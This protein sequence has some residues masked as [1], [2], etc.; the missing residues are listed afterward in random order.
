MKQST[1][2]LS[3]LLA[4]IMAFSC[5]AVIGNAALAEN[6]VAYDNIDDADLT[7]EQV[8]DLALDLVDNDLL[9]DME[10]ID[11]SIV[12]ELRLNSVDNI[13]TDIEDLTGG[14]VWTIGK[15]LLGDI[16]DMNFDALGGVRR[17]GGDLNVINALLQFLADNAG[18]V[19]KIAYGI[20]T[21]N[22]ISLG[23]VGSFL[24]LDKETETMLA[25]LPTFLTS[26][27]FDMLLYGSYNY[28]NDTEELGGI[29]NLPENANTLDEI[30]KEALLQ[31]L[32]DPQDYSWEGEGEDAVKVW[33]DTSKIAALDDFGVS[34]RDELWALINPLNL[35][36]FQILDNIAQPAI[37][38]FGVVALNN[39]LKKALMEAVEVEFNEID[40]AQIKD[41]AVLEYFDNEEAY[42]S[43]IA[44]DAL[45]KASNGVWYYTTLKNK[46]VDADADGVTD[47]DEEGN[48]LYEKQR[49]YYRANFA[50]ANEFATMINWDWNFVASDSS[51]EGTSLLYSELKKDGSIVSG[52]NWLLEKVYDTAL[53]A[54]T[55]ADYE[56]ATGGFVP[57]GND[58]LMEN[59]L[60]LTKY[61]LGNFGEKI[62]GTNSP[63]A[64]Y[65]YDSFA[66]M[67]LVDIIAMIGPGFFEDAMP[68]IILPKNADGSYAFHD[69]VQIWEFAAV[70]LRELITGIAPNV[71]YDAVIFA[72]GDVT[73]ADDRLFEVYDADTWLNILLNM[74]M[75]LAYTYLNNITNFSWNDS[76]R[77]ATT[78]AMASVDDCTEG[79]W[80]SMLD[81]VIMWCVDYVGS[82]SNGVL[83]GISPDAVAAIDG[84][85]NKLDYILNSILPLGLVGEAYTTDGSEE[86]GKAGINLD[87]VLEGAKV[88]LTEFDLTQ[89]L[90]LFGRNYSGYNLLGTT[91][92]VNAVLD[93]VNDIL[94][95]V[96]DTTILQGVNA[97]GTGELT[98][99]ANQSIDAVLTQANLKTTV[100]T[101]LNALNNIKGRLLPTALPVVGKLIDGW[102]TEQEF[103]TP[104]IG[105]SKYYDGENGAIGTAVTVNVRNKSEGVWRHYIDPSTGDAAK[106][107]QYTIIPVSVAAYNY[108]GSTSSYMTPAGLTTSAIGYGGTGSFTFTASAIPTTGAL[109]R[110][111]V[112]YKVTDERGNELLGGK[113]FT[114]TQWTYL[115]YNRTDERTYVENKSTLL[116]AAL[117]T[118]FYVPLSGGVDA[119]RGAQVGKLRRDYKVF[120][121][122]QTGKLTNNSGTVDGL[123]PAS[124]S[125][126]FSNPSRDQDYKSFD[127]LRLFD[128]YTAYADTKEGIHEASVTTISG[129]IN[130]A[131]WLAANKQSGE[132]SVW[133]YTLTDKDGS[134]NRDLVL[135]Y[136]DDVYKD[137]L[138]TLV[139]REL[140]KNPLSAY[141][142][143]T[144][145]S[146]AKEV[147]TSED[148]TDDNGETVLRQ[149]NFATTATVD[150]VEVTAIDNAAAWAEYYAALQYG[151]QVGLQAFNGNKTDWNFKAIYERLQVAANDAEYI[152]KTSTELAASGVEV[153]DAK[154]AIAELQA[155]LDASEATRTDL[156]NFTD[157]KM[158]RLNRYNDAREDVQWYL[159]LLDDASPANVDEIDEY[160]DY[161]WM[162]ENDFRELVAKADN[163]FDATTKANLLALLKKLEAEEK[164]A[165]AAWLQ[166]KKDHLASIQLIDVAMDSNLL[167]LTEDRLLKREGA[168]TY[169]DHINDEIAS[170]ENMITDSSLY[171]ASSWANYADALA[172]AKEAAQT[173]SQKQMFDAKYELLVQ[174]KRLVKI[175]EEADYSELEA[176]IEQAKFALENQDKYQNDNYDFGRV[177]AELGFDEN[178]TVLDR[179]GYEFNL[180]PGSAYEVLYRGYGID[181]QNKVDN[182]ARALKEAL[183]RLKFNEVAVAG[184]GATVNDVTLVE[185]DEEKGIEAVVAKIANISANLD[186]A[187]VKELF[188]VTATGATVGLDN[189]TVS[190]DVNYAVDYETREDFIGF[191]GTNAT[192]TFYTVQGGVKIP[193]ATVKLVVDGDIN[194]DGTVDVLDASYGALIAQEKGEL[195]GCYLLAGN[196]TTTDDTADVKVNTHD[197]SA[198]VN[199][200]LA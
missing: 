99:T 108:D 40:R 37:D 145:T 96:F 38:K 41:V 179:N 88:L 163:N 34:T 109:V 119:I 79:R 11:L 158:Y 160:F 146:Y 21:D 186:E 153:D 64:E 50:A 111:D 100:E 6:D 30:V 94:A 28:P 169:K 155:Q 183:A 89:L 98:T 53:T 7:P 65:T 67:D 12:G 195:T 9:A 147:L 194:G 48:E 31:L 140:D 123:T 75:D 141:Y 121:S 25:N 110:V 68:Q 165:K 76:S 18:R 17:S 62:W 184:T 47:T 105:L 102:G 42:V 55:K 27:V 103:Q 172:A 115:N 118:P 32:L 126:T 43:Y 33:D 60:N 52:I 36:L 139:Y 92:L 87:A 164:T 1:K 156:Y 84:P 24:K 3:L 114:S 166:D 134:E 54:E 80:K 78:T 46:P 66:D 117:Y 124:V 14:F 168:G 144:G 63:Y 120:T 72:N 151:A 29:M 148:T 200:A 23:L 171:T 185:A 5:M 176:L 143:T 82:G 170:A 128:N 150:N 197:Y 44:Y 90:N 198:I 107:K 77:E 81:E 91:S 15:G 125:I 122:S 127:N 190:N 74:G 187:A 192:V 35:S 97:P 157:Y 59:V 22:G 116:Y 13:L 19:S 177:L 45:K 181:D 69:G 161:N 173:D 196:L 4:L 95:L 2:L 180:F 162:E 137:K 175:G 199:L 8:A 131:A 57:G 85:L 83:A 106:D 152:R 51:D 56:A 189:I 20:G 138:V 16:G 73:S 86:G 113:V 182:A 49:V 26:A 71:N 149:T 193:V 174:R 133:N 178:T 39:N 93:L 58:V 142:N 135:K 132:T 154:G 70:V 10:T 61:V 136:Y 167:D 112:K 104:E 191:A 159:N 130:E 101:L 129:S 188:T